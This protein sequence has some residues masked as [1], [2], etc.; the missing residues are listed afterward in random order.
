MRARKV[1]RAL[2]ARDLT[3][4][5]AESCTGGRLGDRITEVPGSS[6]YFLGGVISYSNEAKTDILGVGKALVVLKPGESATQEE[7]IAHVR[8]Q[9]AGY[10]AP[11]SVEFWDEF[12]KGGTGKILKRDIR[13]PFWEGRQKK[14]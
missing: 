5:V 14:V 12:P 13:A 2:E 3:L 1:G 9:L 8:E 11:K 4:A 10:K 6:S 7:I